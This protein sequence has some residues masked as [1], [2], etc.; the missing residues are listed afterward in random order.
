MTIE[1]ENVSLQRENVDY[2]SGVSLVIEPGAFNI[3]LG[4][5]LSGKTTMLRTMAGLERPDQGRILENGVDVTGTPVQ[6]RDVAMVYQQFINYPSMNVFENIASPLRVAR[7]GQPEIDRRVREVARLLRIEPMLD[8]RPGELSG[9]QQQRAALARALVK[10]AGLVL[11]D[12]PLANLDYKL[13]EE[14]REELPRLFEHS[15]STVVYATA[16]PA[17][18]LMLG[19]Y[20]ATLHQGRVTQFGGTHDVFRNPADLITAETFSDPPL[21]VAEVVK[22]DG[23]FILND[24][25]SW[26]VK[27]SH[28]GQPDGDYLLG[29]RPHHLSLGNSDPGSIRL[30]GV[31]EIAEISGSETFVHLEVGDHQWISQSPGVHQ[32]EVGRHLTVSVHP[33]RFMLFAPD[34]RRLDQEA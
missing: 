3:L 9:G 27:E 34:G 1:L 21:N 12:E 4:P 25:T 28:A 20:T 15:G 22:H 31:V 23:H 18:A 10:E 30:E 8:R 26:P 19:G 7:V 14:L 6:K 29:F 5:T 16:E 33:D 32:L 17:E 2:L 13:R 11:L 24:S